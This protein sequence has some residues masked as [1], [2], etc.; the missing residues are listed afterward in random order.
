MKSFSTFL[1]VPVTRVYIHAL[2]VYVH[3][4][5]VKGTSAMHVPVCG[6]Q[7]LMLEFIFNDH[8]YL[9]HGGRDS[10]SNP[11]LPDTVSL[12]KPP[13]L[14][15]LCGHFLRLKLQVG[16]HT[17]PESP[18]VSGHLNYRSHACVPVALTSHWF[19]GLD[20]SSDFSAALFPSLKP[21]RHK[22][23]F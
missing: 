20:D 7:M 14:G 8:F 16:C 15:I 9:I 18:S 23:H 5:H 4:L 17:H 2:H 19:P 1:F 10:Q 6:G 11:E 3:A 21:Q 22:K 12:A 13:N